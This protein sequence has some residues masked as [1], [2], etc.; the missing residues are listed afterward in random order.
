VVQGHINITAQKTGAELSIPIHPE[1]GRMLRAC[2]KDGK[3]FLATAYGKVRSE[4]AFTGFI[5]DAA[6]K[7]GIEGQASPHGLRKAACRRLAEAGCSTHE[8][9]SITGHT[10]VKEIETYT[11]AVEQKILAASAMTKMRGMFDA[12]MTNHLEKLVNPGAN[13]LKSL[14]KLKRLVR[15]RGIEPLFAP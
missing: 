12:E 1:L 15:P 9:M 6:M 11:K 4:K 10:N 14:E 13:P 3:T 2:P 8:I 7:A 5:S